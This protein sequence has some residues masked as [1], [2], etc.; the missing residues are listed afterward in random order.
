[1]DPA[2][3]AVSCP[4]FVAIYNT[5][6]ARIP[7]TRGFPIVSS[8]IG[9]AFAMTSQVRPLEAETDAT[10]AREAGHV[11]W[12][13]APLFTLTAPERPLL[14]SAVLARGKNVSFDPATGAV[15]GSAL[16]GE[17]AGSLKT[18]LARFSDEALAL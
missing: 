7:F 1:M 4:R 9:G 15:G 6:P 5:C 11:L 16:T 14:S 3:N 13:Q 10:Q 12:S 17:A 8:G 2:E 18:M